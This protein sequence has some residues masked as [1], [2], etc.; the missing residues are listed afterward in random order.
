MA[1]P[2]LLFRLGQGPLPATVGFR[3]PLPFANA[4]VGAEE[5]IE[6]P[7][8][9][10]GIRPFYRPTYYVGQAY[11]VLPELTGH[12]Y[13]IVGVVGEADAIL[14]AI[15]GSARGDVG[16]AGEAVAKV[17][18]CGRCGGAIGVNAAGRAVVQ[19]KAKASAARGVQ[20]NANVQLSIKGCAHGRNDADDMTAIVAILMAA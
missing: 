6:Q 14:P 5:E 13:G 7:Q 19:I 11:G 4:G 12:A 9:G 2:F 8:P 20:G 16:E 17:L 1:L 10:G 18:I 15:S 3:G